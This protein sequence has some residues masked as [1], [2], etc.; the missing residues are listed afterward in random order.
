M[1]IIY[2]ARNIHN[3]KMYIGKTMN[4]LEH[5]K[6]KH[7]SN[8]GKPR[9]YFHS[10]IKKYGK[11]SFLWS[12]LDNSEL[13][14]ELSEL[15]KIYIDMFSTSISECGY[16]TTHGG[17]GCTCNDVVKGKISVAN[18]GK[19]RTD[20]MKQVQSEIKKKYYKSNTPYWLGKSRGHELMSHISNV[21]E[22]EHFCKICGI[23]FKS[24]GSRLQY[25]NKCNPNTQRN[26]MGAFLTKE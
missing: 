15:E 4:T 6:R 3:G 19:V 7:E 11:E 26:R 14:S 17:D 10:A 13:D 20:S 1:G 22:Y 24:K 12:I 25:C 5:R 8:S 23:Y 16:N 18:T 2:C 21:R 9:C